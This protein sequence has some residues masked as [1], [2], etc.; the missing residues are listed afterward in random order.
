MGQGVPPTSQI[1]VTTS[2][3]THPYH[4]TVR[5]RFFFKITRI[6]RAIVYCLTQT[7]CLGQSL[8]ILVNN[9]E[10][11]RVPFACKEDDLQWAGVSCTEDEPCPVYLELSS[12]APSGRRLFLSG[13]LHT[14][15]ATLSSVLLASD[16]GGATW[17]EPAPRMR[18]NAIDQV[19]FY[20]LQHGWAAGETQYPLARDPFLLISTDGGQS[21]HQKTVLEDG[22]AG[23]VMRF[24]FDSM[25][26]GE[27]VVDAGK[28]EGKSRYVTYESQTGG[29]S[30][31]L[32][33]TSDRQPAAQKNVAEPDW[34]IQTAKDGKAWQVEKRDGGKWQQLSAFLVEAAVCKGEARELV[35]PKELEEP[36]A[37]VPAPGDTQTDPK[38]RPKR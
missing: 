6:I 14:N 24:A 8:S 12:I 23:S 37:P 38:K 16:D 1:P 35:E 31:N 27:L 7:L 29:E 5:P 18:G 19:E 13:N 25:E 11:L 26:H 28:S 21:W 32:T 2:G 20:D 33:G 10:P 34:R 30:W 36:V 3:R 17:K 15:A 4:P 9:G 22:A